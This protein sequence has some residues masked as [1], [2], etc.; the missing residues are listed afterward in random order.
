MRRECKE[1]KGQLESVKIKT[2]TSF[3][4]FPSRQNKSSHTDKI[5]QFILWDQPD[6]GHFLLMP[7]E[8]KQ[9]FP[10]LIWSNPWPTPYHLRTFQ[11]CQ[12]SVNHL[13]EISFSVFFVFLRAYAWDFLFYIL[14]FQFRLKFFHIVKAER[15]FKIT[16]ANYLI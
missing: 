4:N 1:G 9:Y 16:Q 2:E 13:Q 6:L 10:W 14:Q 11:H 7:M 8:C 15:F 3:K 12:F 5:I